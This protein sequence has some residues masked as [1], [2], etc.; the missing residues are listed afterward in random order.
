MKKIILLWIALGTAQLWAVV[1]EPHTVAVKMALGFNGMGGGILTVNG[2]PGSSVSTTAYD[3]WS[4]TENSVTWLK[5][6]KR[7]DYSLL[8][9]GPWLYSLSFLAP[10]GYTVYLDGLPADMRQEVVPER[11]DGT[12]IGG[13]NRYGYIEVRANYSRANPAEFSGI[14]M[15]KSIAWEIGLGGLINGRSAGKVSFRELDLVTNAP[16]NRARLEYSAPRLNAT[17]SG[18][19]PIIDVIRDSAG[20]IKQ[21]MAPQ[22]FVSFEDLTPGTPNAGYTMKFYRPEDAIFGTAEYAISTSPSVP[23]PWRKIRV[24][25]PD[26]DQLKI[27]EEFSG[28][29]SRVSLLTHGSAAGPAV[30]SGGTVTTVDG[31]KVHAFNAVG[32][33][34]FT[35]LT[36]VTV[37]AVIVGGGGGGATQHAGGG[38]AGGVVSTTLNL[39]AG[40]YPIVVG[41]GGL[42]NTGYNAFGTAYNG[43]AGYNSIAFSLSA[44]GGGHGSSSGTGG[45]GGSGGGSGYPDPTLGGSGTSGQGNTGNVS[46]TGSDLYGGGGG[47]AGGTGAGSDGGAAVST[48]AG[49]LAGGGGGGFYGGY[50]GGGGAGDGGYGGANGGH[51]TNGT[52]SGG[53]G[54][55]NYEGKGGNGASGVVYIRYVGTSDSS[56]YTLKEGDGST[57]ERT[58]THASTDYSGSREE[59]VTVYTGSNVSDPATIVAKTKYRYE[60]FAGGELTEVISNPD[61]S[62]NALTTKYTY[63]TNPAEP[64]N[65]RRVESVTEPSGKWVSYRY[66]DDWSRRGQ[67]DVESRP[68]LDSPGVKQSAWQTVGQSVT[69]T[70]VADYTGRYRLPST[71]QEWVGTQKIGKSASS[72]TQSNVR[73]GQF[74]TQTTVSSFSSD[75]ASVT[76]VSEYVQANASDAD[77]AG[78]PLMV[79]RPDGTQDSYAYHQGTYNPSTK[80]FS[81][82]SGGTHFRETVWHGTNT[83]IAGGLLSSFESFDIAPIY[84]S[85]MQSTKDVVIRNKAGLVIRR[86]NWVCTSGTTFALVTWEDYTYDEAGRL[87]TTAASN[88]TST[89]NHF[90]TSGLAEYT[91]NA[92]GVRTNFTGYDKIGRLTTSVQVGQTASGYTLPGDITTTTTFDGANRVTKTKVEASSSTP[93]MAKTEYDLSG[94][95]L[96]Q[97]ANAEATDTT[98]RY[99]TIYDYALGGKKVT[100]TFPGDADKTTE[101]HL[102]G[103]IKSV[104]G[105]SG[106]AAAVAENYSYGLDGGGNRTQTAYFGG[107]SAAYTTTVADW[108]GRQVS[109]SKP[110]WSSAIV[111]KQWYYNTAGQL[112]KVTQPGVAP[113]L[114]TYDLLGG[115]K[116]EGLDLA[117]SVGTLDAVSLDRITEYSWT[118][119]NVGTEWWRTQTTKVYKDASGGTKQTSQISTQLAGFTA[120]ESGYTRIAQ[121]KSTDMF[122]NV[123]TTY[124][125]IKV[126]DKT[127][128]TTTNTPDSQI[129]AVETVINGRQVS[130][131]DTAGIVTKFGY[132]ALGRQNTVTNANVSPRTPLVTTTTYLPGTTMVDEVTQ[133]GSLVLARYE[134]NSAGQPKSVKATNPK[135]GTAGAPQFLTTYYE[136]TSRGEKKRVWGDSEYP[137]SYGYND[138]GLQTAMTTYQG[139]TNWNSASWPTVTGAGNT[140]TWI[141][142][143]HTNLLTSKVDA[144]NHSVDYTYT[145]AGQLYTRTWARNRPGSSTERLRTTY[146]YS[147]ETGEHTSVTYNDGITFPI[148]YTYNRLGLLETV[149]D[150]TYRVFTYNL[151]G[152]LEMLS[153]KF[154]TGVFGVNRHI[155]YQYTTTGMLGRPAGYTIDTGPSTT[156]VQTVAYGYDDGTGGTGR[157]K[158]VTADSRV[159]QYGYQPNSHLVKTIENAS[160]GYKDERTYHSLHDWTITRHTT[161]GTGTDNSR[162]KFE[163]EHD[164]VGRIKNTTKTGDLFDRYGS[165]TTGLI[166]KYGYDD[167][168][169]VTAET[170]TERNT[171]LTPVPGRK[172]DHATSGGYSYDNIGNRTQTV[173]NDQTST[174]SVNE[175]N[176]YTSRTVPGYVDV[177]GTA[178]ST[179]TVTITQ[180]SDST[181]YTT[182]RGSGGDYFFRS[183]AM[184][185]SVNAVYRTLTINAP[186]STPP[187]DTQKVFLPKTPELAST[188]Y[189]L[190]G[191]LTSDG[192]WKYTYDAENRLIA[193]ETN[194]DAVPADLPRQKFTLGY[195]YMGRRIVKGLETW[196]SSTNQYD[197]TY[198]LRLLYQGW[199]LIAEVD[200]TVSTETLTKQYFWG[201]D[202]SGSMQGA[203][204]VGGLLMFKEGFSQYLPMYDAMGNV[205]GMLTAAAKTFA[206]GTYA[207]GEIVAGYEFDAFGQT[208]R[209]SGPISTSNPMRY[210]TK[211]TD[212]DTGLVYY[213]LRY[214][215]PS[216]GRFINK[217]P[218]A[219][220]GGLNLYAFVANNAVNGY[221]YLGMDGEIIWQDGGNNIGRD[222]LSSW[223]KNTINANSAIAQIGGGTGEIDAILGRL[224]SPMDGSPVEALLAQAGDSV[225]EGMAEYLAGREALQGMGLD[226]DAPAVS[227]VDLL[228]VAQTAGS[229]AAHSGNILVDRYP[230]DSIF[231]PATFAD[232]MNSPNRTASAGAAVLPAF[233]MG[234][235]SAG[236]SLLSSTTVATGGLVIVAAGSFYAGYQLGQF[237]DE[238]TGF[239]SWVADR[240]NGPLSDPFIFNTHAHGQGE[241]NRAAN[242]SGSG[243]QF[244]K[245]KPDPKNSGRVITRDANG[246]ETSKAK[247]PGFDEWWNSK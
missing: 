184:D 117:G 137:V 182:E 92:E 104:S 223:L 17:P 178:S 2:E 108:L 237:I 228:R 164:A 3:A 135:Y 205:H 200:A 210:S 242:P 11:E 89:L 72:Y 78:L 55:G 30:A 7:Y 10:D 112:E 179:S 33:G 138:S 98:K 134:Y 19:R 37:D 116:Q 152:N 73:N 145:D 236:A 181:N 81:P 229:L 34:T 204:G 186:G 183:H 154:P 88:G 28:T 43:Q 246:K 143:A 39:A 94:R 90:G 160:S 144:L 238:R 76:S 122:S 225:R 185:N 157:L 162:A 1:P 47:G 239:S 38:G 191:N 87:K 192:R 36:P 156:A 110:A 226:P 62:T 20:A 209:E 123:T 211:Y 217:D 171:A 131:Q 189:D 220:S 219:E 202:L 45:S 245:M 40:S 221:D 49:N 188:S 41:A 195:D 119:V 216:L 63:H 71:F 132:D 22:V 60:S 68:W 212:G 146:G 27:T 241:R 227:L 105:T 77:Q 103:R 166:T 4:E 85:P 203:G 129:D 56:V 193:V 66:Y 23:E 46:S 215:S 118:F 214:Y 230:D 168:S 153:E 100:V 159:F 93:L 231:N 35:V 57:W 199:N 177:A 115:L 107:N 52:G 247:P 128:K 130:A 113:T 180:L 83:V 84:L 167:R 161:W 174:Y 95:V 26:S 69:K 59:V 13:Y 12:G 208:I 96:K 15:G 9:S 206:S 207:A 142:Q 190:D 50:S 133:P 102:D 197:E 74:Y 187:S 194:I 196:N 32:T 120:V 172:N 158:T 173:H 24:E 67:I 54:G 198:W 224:T 213:G 201:L 151:S 75:T 141:Y 136:Y 53:G 124:T 114:Y 126:S 5:P 25:S 58:T 235:G 163:Y 99:E 31:Y 155:S 243:D 101:I 51:A 150:R 86:E 148:T 234:S 21:I 222:G 233:T 175:L 29:Y 44:V 111:S 149:A 91:V 42:G 6:G 140:T 80:D 70:Y 18:T 109:E 147:S 121:T 8:A 244:K 65:Y 16:A 127:R 139:G 82:A 48:W 64:G 232:V 61:S 165:S 79:R 97:T 106:N 125:E 240:I 169:Q 218:I 14:R 176:Q 170:T